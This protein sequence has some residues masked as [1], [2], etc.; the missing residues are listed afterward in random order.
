MALLQL[1]ADAVL[2]QVREELDENLAAQVV[3]LVLDA[4]GQQARGIQRE[5]RA[6]AIEG[7]NRNAL[8]LN[9]LTRHRL[10][11]WRFREE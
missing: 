4:G 6:V 10:Y 11:I 2:L 8:G 3:H 5:A 1:G 9:I 7:S